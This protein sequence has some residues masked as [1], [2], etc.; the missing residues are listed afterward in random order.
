MDQS[1]V[2]H[3]RAL[4]GGAPVAEIRLMR[5]ERG[6]ALD[7]DMLGRIARI[8][9]DLAGEEALRAVLLTGEGRHFCAGADL[10]WM[11]RAAELSGAE[12]LRDA[13]HLD[14]ALGSLAALP[15]PLIAVVQG[16]CY[17]GGLGLISC[18]DVAL[19]E[20]S[21]TFRFSEPRLGLVPA[22]I[23]PFV[24]RAIGLRRARRR[25][26][27]AEP[28]GA[29]EAWA[30]GLVH[31]VLPAPA[32]Q[33]RIEALVAAIAAC[34]PQALRQCKALLARLER[35][36]GLADETDH[37]RALIARMRTTPE[38][39]EGMA[40]FLA[41]RPPAWAAASPDAD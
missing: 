27:T 31:E 10:G 25:F 11:R 29:D 23:S 7:E 37:A 12:N 8:A 6:N 40:A 1:V 21:A 4:P 17:G 9:Q 3:R 14:R 19:A 33:G 28:F 2:V 15:V 41:K 24:V 39:Q 32:M 18:A 36:D 35:H 30:D 26:L 22:V 34:G 5:P 38:A 16:C 13:A 20:A